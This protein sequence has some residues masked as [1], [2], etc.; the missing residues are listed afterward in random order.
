MRQLLGRFMR[1]YGVGL[2][3]VALDRS[4]RFK[5]TSTNTW[6]SWSRDAEH[7]DISDQDRWGAPL[8]DMLRNVLTRDLVE[9]LGAGRVFAPDQSRPDDSYPVEVDVLQLQSDAHGTVTFEG[10]W[11]IAH[12]GAAIG[13]NRHFKEASSTSPTDYA[14]QV[15]SMSAMLGRLA[16][17][18][19]R[20]VNSTLGA[21][22]P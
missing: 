9:R 5:F 2:N 11:S 10:T 3:H 20:E 22:T 21:T 7:M 6:A 13:L 1:D 16:D 15:A 14:A 4:A 18:I 8:D 17:Q 19:A 12:T